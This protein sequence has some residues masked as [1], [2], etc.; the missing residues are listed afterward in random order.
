MSKKIA[1]LFPGQGAQYVGMGRDFYD[2]F[3][4]VRELYEEAEERL[5]RRLAPIA[6]EGP[7]ER[8]KETRNSQVAIYLNSM[9]LLRVLE[10][11]LPQLAPA[12]CAGLS[13]GEYSA[14]TAAHVLS[15]GEALE[16]V[17]FR[18]A[19]MQEA[20]EQTPGKMA[21]VLG[22]AASQVEAVVAEV[23]PRHPLWVANYNTPGQIVLSGSAAGVEAGALLA[24]ERGAKR[25]LPLQV[26]GAFHSGFMHSA[27]EKLKKKLAHVMLA[28][29]RARVVLNVLGEVAE[30]EAIREAL[31]SQVTHSVRW[32]QSV[33]TMERTG[34][35][36]YVEIG[37]GQTLT[38]M[39]RQ[40]GVRGPTY[41]VDKVT[42][43]EALGAIL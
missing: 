17:D 33:E 36:L 10:K 27:E 34:V 7:V 22:L 1:Y 43:L 4:E 40:I 38:G 15:F 39:N 30:G 32:Q 26:Q 5:K 31:G 21:V 13:L 25:V 19:A 29:P 24:K 42:D 6:F 14:L 37:C 28:P 12:I 20:C 18:G 3:S 11:Q 35:D 41:S 16:L 2:Q 9:A 23:A 8:L